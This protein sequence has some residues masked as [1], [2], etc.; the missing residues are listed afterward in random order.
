[1]SNKREDVLYL[2]LVDFFLQMLFLVMIAL[3]FYIAVQQAN[4]KELEKAAKISKQAQ[5]W[6][7]LAKKYNIDNVQELLDRLTTLAPIKNLEEAKKAKDLIDDNGGLDA[8]AAILKKLKEGQG[9][10]PCI[11][12]SIDNKT[13]KSVATFLATNTT[14]TLVNWQPEFAELAKNLGKGDLV[15]DTQ[16]G[17]KEFV[18]TW[19]GVL[20]KYPECRYTVTL[21]ERTDLVKPR[22]HVQSVFYA[23]IRR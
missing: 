7:D 12:Q 9:K 21:Q 23:Q 6:E 4:L 20:S 16:W 22:D 15:T 8:V 2:T 13:P 10:P 14:I 18:S 5:Q 11:V 17:L 1:M 19:R 3:L